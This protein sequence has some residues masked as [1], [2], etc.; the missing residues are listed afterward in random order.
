MDAFIDYHDGCK[1][2]IKEAVMSEYVQ[3]FDAG[4]SYVLTEIEQW[5]KA[6]DYEPRAVWPVQQ[7]LAK[8]KE[9]GSELPKDR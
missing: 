9:S 8:L 4:Y 7:L 3:G 6:H 1:A 2:P 5:I